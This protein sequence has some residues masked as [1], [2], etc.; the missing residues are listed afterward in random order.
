LAS[1]KLRHPSLHSAVA[2]RS[3]STLLRLGVSW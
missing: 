2:G 1:Q 3:S